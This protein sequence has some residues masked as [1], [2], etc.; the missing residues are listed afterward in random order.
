[1]PDPSLRLLPQ[2][3]WPAPGSTHGAVLLRDRG[4]TEPKGAP[5]PHGG[6]GSG[7]E[8]GSGGRPGADQDNPYAPPPEGSPDRPWRPRRPEGSDGSSGSGGE[9]DQRGGRGPWG[10]QWSDRQP[11]RSSGRFG[12]RPGQQGG[13]PEGQ[14]S[15]M[16]WD[17]TDPSQRRARYSLLTG[18]WAFFFALFSWPYV[19]L[20]LGALA[21]YWGVS[22]VRGAPPRGERSAAGSGAGSGANGSGSG[23]GSGNGGAVASGGTGRVTPRSMSTAAISGLVTGGLAL[24]MVA[25]T[26]TA[27]L[28]YRDYYVCV[29]DALTVPQKESCEGLLPEQL[30]PLLS[31]KD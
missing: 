24:A 7:S 11:G 2:H 17:P 15:G 23:S 1:M 13:G 26:F 25:A 31:T 30:R 12:D 28:V 21:V 9:D 6:E 27:Q 3:T 20:M 5:A 22:A 10:G 18:M 29:R 19:A 8:N 4:Q 16:R 14:Q